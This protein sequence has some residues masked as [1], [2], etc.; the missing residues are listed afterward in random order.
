MHHLIFE[1]AEL[2]GKSWLMSQV[3]NRLEPKYNQGGFVLDGCHWLN[4]DVGI[5]GTENSAPV[6][7][8]YLQIFSALKKQNIIVEKFHLSDSVYQEL[9]NNKIVDYP[10]VEKI[11][12]ELDF[13]IILITMPDNPELISRRLTDRLNLYPHYARIK[14]GPEWYI[15]QQNLYLKKIKNSKLP[16]LIIPTDKLPDEKPVK[17]ILGWLNE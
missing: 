13:K 12:Q 5:F 17:Q 3:Y 15:K 6:I 14:Q 10:A 7:D 16:Y 1:G 4:C 2:T 11:L 8:G 9:F